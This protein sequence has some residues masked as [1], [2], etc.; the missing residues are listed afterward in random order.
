MRIVFLCVMIAMLASCNSQPQPGTDKNETAAAGDTAKVAEE[1]RSNMSYLN[2]YNAI[3]Q[4]FGNENWLLADQK[5]SSYLYL[6]RLGEYSVNIYA[7]KI[8]KGDSAQVKHGKMERKNNAIHWEFDGKPLAVTG[9][10]SARVVSAVPGKDSLQYEFIRTD[11]NHIQLTY[12]NKEKKIL[13]KTLPFSL[14]LIRSR[15]DYTHGTK[16]AFDSVE[17]SKKHRV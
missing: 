14:F 16:L 13:Q 3:E 5:D 6:S 9:A 15:Y 8:I 10:T 11:A 4:V 7:Y 2:D 12:P 17:F 1:I